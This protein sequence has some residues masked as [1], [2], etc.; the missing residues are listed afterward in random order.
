MSDGHRRMVEGKTYSALYMASPFVA[1]F[2]DMRTGNLERSILVTVH[3]LDL[4]LVHKVY[5]S[6]Y[7]WS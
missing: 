7:T 5:L 6:S 3:T 1:E 4:D 2:L